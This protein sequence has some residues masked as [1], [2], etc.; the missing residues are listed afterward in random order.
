[1][2]RKLYEQLTK[3]E[4]FEKVD[5]ID[6]SGI[7]IHTGV[8][9]QG[10]TKLVFHIVDRDGT[11]V[12]TDNGQTLEHLDTVFELSE[13]DVLKNVKAATDYYGIGVKK[14]K[15][16]L[17]INSKGGFTEAYLRMF[18]CV[19]FLRTMKIFYE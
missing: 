18:F 11:F 17:P 5:F 4:L 7:V 1:M 14:M 16:E 15:L 10:H 8:P 12:L 3:N 6:G 9:S 19:G 2:M 13:S